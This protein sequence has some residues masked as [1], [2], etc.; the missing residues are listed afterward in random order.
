MNTDKTEN[1]WSMC[2]LFPGLTSQFR[3]IKSHQW[4][5]YRFS[6][7]PELN[8]HTVSENINYR[9]HLKCWLLFPLFLSNKCSDRKTS[10][11]TLLQWSTGR[12]LRSLHLFDSEVRGDVYGRYIYLTVKYGET[13]YGR[14]IY[15]IGTKEQE[16]NTSNG[17]S[18]H[19]WLYKDK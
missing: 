14:Y 8:Y 2:Q 7:I 5:S 12:R 3:P 6:K 4:S 15:L 11:R 18:F 19:E 1:S 10:P 17:F 9:T 13:F 16:V